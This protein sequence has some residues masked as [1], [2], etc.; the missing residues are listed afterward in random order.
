MGG[1]RRPPPERK[2]WGRGGGRELGGADNA[3]AGSP[4]V[5]AGPLASDPERVAPRTV[6]PRPG[7]ARRREGRTGRA[8]GRG[9][10]GPLSPLPPPH[11]SDV[12]TSRPRPSVGPAPPRFP[13]ADHVLK[14]LR[15]PSVRS[16]CLFG[17]SQCDWELI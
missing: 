3:A 5:G 16:V 12:G 14:E 17:S 1:R 7:R 6:P 9:G 10:E 11:S 13:R 4:A 8:R 2:G 15:R